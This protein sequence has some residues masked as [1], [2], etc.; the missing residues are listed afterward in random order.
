MVFGFRRKET[1]KQ[2]PPPLE[3]SVKLISGSEQQQ[4]PSTQL[5]PKVSHVYEE[6]QNSQTQKGRSLFNVL[7]SPSAKEFTLDGCIFHLENISLTGE[8]TQNFVI[9]HPLK[10][11]TDLFGHAI[12]PVGVLYFLKSFSVTDVLSYRVQCAM[13]KILS[14]PAQKGYFYCERYSRDIGIESFLSSLESSLRDVSSAISGSEL[15]IYE[16]REE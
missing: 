13:H 15:R 8:P 5:S 14:E 9:G 3:T 2:L 10:P 16:R 1:P 12:M 4:L 7:T 11:L 6:E